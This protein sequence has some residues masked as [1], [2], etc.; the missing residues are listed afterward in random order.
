MDGDGSDGVWR[1][2]TG[3]RRNQGYSVGQ[4]GIV[5]VSIRTCGPEWMD[6]VVISEI[7][8]AHVDEATQPSAL[9]AS[10]I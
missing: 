6:D 4:D 5:L 1:D 8:K 10:H 2:G 3:R 9:Q 7:V